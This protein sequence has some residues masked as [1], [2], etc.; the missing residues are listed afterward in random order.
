[1]IVEIFMGFS[2][3]V[4]AALSGQVEVAILEA[5]GEVYILAKEENVAKLS[6][7]EGLANAGTRSKLLVRQSYEHTAKWLEERIAAI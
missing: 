3:A 5:D 1:M 4:S 2:D 7:I 6:A